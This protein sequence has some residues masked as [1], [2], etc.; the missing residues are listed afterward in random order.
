MATAPAE[1]TNILFNRRRGPLFFSS[2][3]E[4]SQRPRNCFSDGIAQAPSAKAFGTNW[5]ACCRFLL[6]GQISRT[7]ETA[8]FWRG[9]FQALK[10]LLDAGCR[11]NLG[12]AAFFFPRGWGVMPEKPAPPFCNSP[13]LAGAKTAQTAPGVNR[14]DVLG[15]NAGPP[16]PGQPSRSLPIPRPNPFPNAGTLFPRPASRP[17]YLD[18]P[19][20]KTWDS[21][22]ALRRLGG[23]LR[24]FRPASFLPPG[25][26]N[27]LQFG[28]E[29]FPKWGPCAPYNALAAALRN[30]EYATKAF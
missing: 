15:A 14:G 1:S 6:L 26:R 17:P 18:L 4:N 9:G 19:A 25:V 27:R 29:R 23:P 3:G 11:K 8:V 28:A 13:P 16:K 7:A 22:V 2:R 24:I 20:Q 21:A 10:S 5:A 30:A 12:C